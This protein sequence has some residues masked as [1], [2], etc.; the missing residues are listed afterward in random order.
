MIK[1]CPI[2]HKTFNDNTSGYNMI[3]C[4]PKCRQKARREKEKEERQR[5]WAEFK[6]RLQEI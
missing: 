3:F 4:C 2:C 6:I 1:F 5:K